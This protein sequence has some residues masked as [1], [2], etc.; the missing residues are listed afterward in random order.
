MTTPPDPAEPVTLTSA[1]SEIEA[2]TIAA[3]LR[4]RGIDAR[5]VGGMIPLRAEVHRETRVMVLRAD[6]ERARL[7]LRAIKA[8][9]VDIAW[10]ELNPGQPEG[11]E[12]DGA[13]PSPRR[14]AWTLIFVFMLPVGL[15][16]TFIAGGPDRDVVVRS[17]GP[18]I[19]TVAAV[20][21]LWLFLSRDDGSQDAGDAAS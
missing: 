2:E 4:E 9:S 13:A 19:L 5:A 10:D 17:L 7:A 20:M 18:I 12:P 14:W 1:S 3:A 15:F 8:D 21:A 16:L 11:P 6:L